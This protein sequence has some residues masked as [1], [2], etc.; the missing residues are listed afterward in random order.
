MKN[1]NF[2][3][4]LSVMSIAAGSL[5]AAHA[6][7]P[8]TNPIERT[9]FTEQRNPSAQS[10]LSLQNNR[11]DGIKRAAKSG[12]EYLMLA[13]SMFNDE[14]VNIYPSGGELISYPV[15]FDFDNEAGKVTVDHLFRNFLEEEELP[16]Q[17]NWD[18]TS[19]RISAQTPPEFYAPDECV[20]LGE[21]YDMIISL[22]AG[23][24]YGIGY[25]ESLPEFVM[26]IENNGNVIVPESGFAMIGNIYDDLFECYYNYS[27]YE[28]IFDAR[29]YKRSEG[30]AIYADRE[31]IDFGETF[32]NTSLS[33]M[34][35]VVN[36]GSEEADFVVS[37]QNSNF[38]TSVTSGFIAPGEYVDIE[39]TFAPESIGD[40]TGTITVDTEVSSASIAL[41]GISRESLD[42]SPIV[43][44][45]YE[46]MHFATG[47]EYPFV[48]NTEL[49]GSPVAI[50]TN[51]DNGRTSSWLEVQIDVPDGERGI[52]DWK[53][54]FNPRWSV[55]D[56][57]IVT[58]NGETV[59][60]TP[61]DDQYVM[62]M[63]SQIGLIPGSHVIRFS[64]N[65][66]TQV[67]P[68]GVELGEDYAYISDINLTMV[69]YIEFA[70][71]ISND[72]YDFGTLYLPEGEQ[73]SVVC[74]NVVSLRN[75]GYGTL[76]VSEIWG[77]DYF[78]AKVSP[79]SIQPEKEGQI[80]IS[81]FVKDYGVTTGEVIIKTN[82]GD[83]IISCEANVE[84]LP[85]YSKIVKQGEFTFECG[86]NPFIVI[87]D[88]AINDNTIPNDGTEVISEF[89]A[90]FEVPRG[91]FGLLTWSGDVDCGN[92]D[93]G[94]IMIDGDAYG[95]G[96][97]EGVG[98]AGNYT[99]KPYQCWVESGSH[100]IS[101]GYQQCGTSEWDGAGTFAIRNLSL[102]IYDEMPKMVFW[103]ETP[104]EFIPVYSGKSDVRLMRVYNMTEDIMAL[105]S[106]ETP[107]Q[108]S[109]KYSIENN[110]QVPQYV[111]C[112]F[113]VFFNP[114]EVGE[115]TGN[116]V[117]KTSLGELEIPVAGTCMDPKD[118]I[119]DEDFEN[120]LDGWTIIDANGDDKTWDEG[121][122]T[123]AYTGENCL[124]FN[125]FFTRIDN[126]D[127][128]VSPEFTIPEGGATI[129]YYRTY[130]KSDFKQTYEVRVGMGDD[131]TTFTTVYEDKDLSFNGSYDHI[132]IPISEF[133]GQTV[134]MCFANITPT[135]D[136]NLLTIDDIVVL[137]GISTVIGEESDAETVDSTFFTTSGLRINNPTK[138]IY[139]IRELKK[140]G[141]VS[142]KKAIKR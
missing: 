127:Y 19:R 124:M 8:K 112:G 107:D 49:T 98:D 17:L 29:F 54:F 118:I 104:V 41:T 66:G 32:V 33:R 78:D 50:S 110:S 23:Y 99:M 93:R 71:E 21:E 26:N 119:F 91:K 72:K 3:I 76:E 129:T 109:V 45:G 18:A 9:K 114:T 106:I 10:V 4:G 128:I 108:F 28:V 42:Y 131:P 77:D 94:L 6:T 14:G 139:L 69:E 46:Y 133:A 95:M 22:Q 20:R 56:S 73:G 7:E 111:S 130:S 16:A 48:I 125:S 65:K 138:G 142:V 141:T 68:I 36:A 35:R 97:Y 67:D 53:G 103:E 58:N 92:G 121:G 105:E 117:V 122:S 60:E 27:Y 74:N 61:S 136:K 57:F 115:H 64:Y 59:Y 39:V 90:R 96:T 2:I 86:G 85:E 134:R 38:I 100:M 47:N 40:I 25:W 37:S 75:T 89:T 84:H 30:V 11:Q 101:F 15:Y 12:S 24:P 83:F 140:D 51:A 13:K 137:R 132:E 82:A 102:E 126:E 31:N 116:V 62:E 70:G 34:F 81:A 120:G 79:M 87:D 55:Y 43:S 123:Y 5:W 113:Y 44:A 80:T 88:T 135:G 63:S 1:P 52:F